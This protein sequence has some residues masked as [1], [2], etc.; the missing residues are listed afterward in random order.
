MKKFVKLTD[1]QSFFQEGGG[2]RAPRVA[3]LEREGGALGQRERLL[4][5][6]GKRFEPG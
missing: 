3:F 5:L 1:A 6:K 2:Y 4:I